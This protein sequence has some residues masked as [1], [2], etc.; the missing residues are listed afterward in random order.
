MNKAGSIQR[1]SSRGQSRGTKNWY[2]MKSSAPAYSL[3]TQKTANSRGQSSIMGTYQSS[4]KN[5][6]NYD[7]SNSALKS[8]IRDKSIPDPTLYQNQ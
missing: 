2:N 7:Y 5:T 8:L 1:N 4:S 6:F 3:S